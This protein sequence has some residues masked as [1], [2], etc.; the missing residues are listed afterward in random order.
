M[1][2]SKVGE[3]LG[4]PFAGGGGVRRIPG[5]VGGMVGRWP[6]VGVGIAAVGG[7]TGGGED[8]SVAGGTEISVVVFGVATPVGVGIANV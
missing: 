2:C 7:S 3:A 4:V 5:M 6:N 1:I 8:T